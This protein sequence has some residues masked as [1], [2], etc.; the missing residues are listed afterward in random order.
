M[1]N[2]RT[3]DM[4]AQGVLDDPNDLGGPND[5]NDPNDLGDPNALDDMDDEAAFVSG[6]ESESESDGELD[7]E[8]DPGPAPAP[9]EVMTAASMFVCTDVAR[10]APPAPGAFE[11]LARGCRPGGLVRAV[12]SNFGHVAA[13]GWE[14]WLKSPR[15]R[16]AA[17]DAPGVPPPR[18]GQGDSTC[19]N[20]AIEPVVCLAPGVHPAGLPRDVKV[21][22]IKFF[23]STGEIQIPGVVAAD[24]SDGVE[25]VA[26]LVAWLNSPE[27]SPLG[28]GPRPVAVASHR[29]KMLNYKWAV[30]WA[31]LGARADRALVD[32][33]ELAAALDPAAAPP[34]GRREANPAPLPPPPFP[35]SEVAPPVNDVKVS[36]KLATGDGRRAR[37]NFFQSGRVNLLGAADERTASEA[38]RWLAELL[39]TR[40]GDLARLRPLTDAER[41]RA[42]ASAN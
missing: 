37:V 38:R 9:A 32:I 22:K 28:T 21:Y 40:W 24:R 42:R 4:V 8:D 34:R 27:G 16:P 3:A 41:A 29:P 39:S 15:A 7:P 33:R 12:N 26:A 1:A 2:A 11:A 6:D 13:P 35:V 23:P 31:P 19:F 20:S 5:P 30:D 17:G 14:P 36:F 18:R 25:V 10:V